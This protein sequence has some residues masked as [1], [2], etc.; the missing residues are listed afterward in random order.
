MNHSLVAFVANEDVRMVKVTFIDRDS[1]DRGREYS[2]KTADKTVTIGDLVVV[3]T[4]QDMDNFVLAEVTG[5]DAEFNYNDTINY[6]WI[7]AKVDLKAYENILTQEKALID[8]Y[9]AVERGRIRENMRKAMVDE[10]GP[11]VIARLGTLKTV[12]NTN[13]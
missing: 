6:R 8:N 9:K 13:G 3:P 1:K 4:L 11:D 7:A 12:E 10:L 2:Y 5:L